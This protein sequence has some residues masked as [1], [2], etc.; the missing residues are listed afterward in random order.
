MG[1]QIPKLDVREQNN[2]DIQRIMRRAWSFFYV[3]DFV[4]S[5]SRIRERRS[6]SDKSCQTDTKA[7]LLQYPYA[8]QKGVTGWRLK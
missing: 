4:N 5:G 6:C 7:A 3:L 2:I 8:S 1:P